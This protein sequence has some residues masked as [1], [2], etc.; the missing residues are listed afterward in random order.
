MKRK[1]KLTN[2]TK[3]GFAILLTTA[4]SCSSEDSETVLQNELTTETATNVANRT[5]CNETSFP[6]LGPGATR[7]QVRGCNDVSNPNN[8]GTLDCRSSEGGYRNVSGGFGEYSIT[9]STARFDG[10]RTRVERFFNSISRTANRTST[11]TYSFIIDDVSSGSTCI[12]Q[13]HATGRIV[14][15]SRTGQDARSA[16]FLLYVKRALRNGSPIRD[17]SGR[18]VYVLEVHESTT[19]FTSTNRGTRTITRLRNVTQG[20]Q[21]NLSYR[22]GYDENRNAESRISVSGGGN[23]RSRNLQHNY[24]TERITTRYGA[25]EACDV[26]SDDEFQIR[27]KNTQFCRTN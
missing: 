17:S 16:L 23:T 20:V 27:I 25:Y 14:A 3:L 21:Y 4:F 5:N 10:T 7:G 8:I 6:N 26:C 1:L 2:F 18:E 13:S 15:G 22:T 19:P 24:T 12:V 11:L 9:G